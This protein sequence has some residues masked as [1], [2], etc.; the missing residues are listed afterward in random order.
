MLEQAKMVMTM[1]MVWSRNPSSNAMQDNGKYIG[2][3]GLLQRV[4]MAIGMIYKMYGQ[5]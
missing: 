5:R 4:N 1:M 2:K 3:E